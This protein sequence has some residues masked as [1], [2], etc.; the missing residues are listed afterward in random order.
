MISIILPVKDG[1]DDLRR[2]L[3]RIARQRVEHQIETLVVDSGSHDDSVRVA[4]AH[5]ARVY[6]TMAGEFRHGRTRNFGA[7]HASGEFLVFTSQDAYAVSDDWLKRLTAPLE[8]DQ[9]LA[10]VYGRQIP[11]EGASPPEEFFLR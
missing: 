5:G 1:G 3:E 10:G 4:R 2:C 8:T 6:E 9:T 11:H 7:R